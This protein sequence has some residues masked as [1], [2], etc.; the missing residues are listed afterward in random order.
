[1]KKPIKVVL[2]ILLVISFLSTGHRSFELFKVRNGYKTTAHV[3]DIM[4]PQD[5]VVGTYT[6]QNKVVHYE[7]VL[8]LDHEYLFSFPHT[9]IGTDITIVIDP[10]TGYEYMYAKLIL[11]VVFY[12]LTTA[13]LALAVFAGRIGKRSKA[14]KK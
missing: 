3:V 1:M 7:E 2:C 14:V 10:N 4:T 12:S 6:D 5:L 13:A 9:R 8:Y 11:S